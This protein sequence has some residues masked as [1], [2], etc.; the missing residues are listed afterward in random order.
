MDMLIVLKLIVCITT[1][2]SHDILHR[3]YTLAS[4][5]NICDY[6]IVPD[7]INNPM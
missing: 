1:E 4:G 5:G 6:W 2:Y 3:D 7:Q